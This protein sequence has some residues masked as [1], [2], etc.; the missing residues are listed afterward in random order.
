MSTQHNLTTSKINAGFLVRFV[1]TWIDIF[2]VY[3]VVKL[4]I[5][6]LNQV[7][8]YV[9]LEITV[10]ISFAAYSSIL[11]GRSGSSVG[12]ALCSLTIQSPD[13]H[14]PGY[15][16]ALFRETICKIISAAFV[17]LGFIWI[18]FSRKKRGWHDYI[19]G[20]IVKQNSKAVMRN[21]WL[22]VTTIV[23]IFL[24]MGSKFLLNLFVYLDSRQIANESVI[25]TNYP[26]K[27]LSSLIEV[28]TLN[29]SDQAV[30]LKWL[31]ENSKDPIDYAVETAMK[32]Q[33]TIFEEK[34]H[35]SDDLIFLNNLVSDL[36]H[37]SGI[38]CIAVEYLQAMN[39]T[40]IARLVTGEQFDSELA[41]EI[42]R[43]SN[44]PDWG[45]KE[46]WDIFKTVWELNKSLPEGNKKLRLVGID[47]PWDLPSLALVL[48][49]NIGNARVSTPVYEKLRIFRILDDIVFLESRDA[50]MARNVEREI[51]EKDERAIIWV[52]GGHAYIK[53][54]QPVIANNMIIRKVSRMGFMLHKKYGDR[55]FQIRMH[56]FAFE[57]QN[58][59]NFI[60]R[61]MVQ[62]QNMS[63]G[64]DVSGSPFGDLKDNS[65]NYYRVQ[66]DLCFSDMT[67]G[68][69][70]L[71]PIQ[72][73]T[74]CHWLD[75]FISRNM[76]MQDKPYFEVEYGQ[77]LYDYEEAN[78][79]LHSRYSQP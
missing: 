55:V 76:F 62:S 41:L 74:P 27:E 18:I 72:K 15:L 19:A 16:R 44:W 22:L 43:S 63:V 56:D 8:I 5:I 52:G 1:A 46:Y 26:R 17:C 68:Y 34:H 2:M 78:K 35:I 65:S 39:N 75:G 57:S 61:V 32:Y 71:K 54:Q 36:Y 66:P 28:N 45:G 12:K 60:E 77:K 4:V 33:I 24:S 64:F 42:A 20:T 13:G 14:G 3:A 73:Q 58:I 6:V 21:R 10:I 40:K 53:F 67:T 7:D 50:I 51:I 30:F 70:F 9:P 49:G 37:R 25:C 79:L 69:I 29:V 31:N 47:H 48:G 23:L 59:T 38:T 11:V